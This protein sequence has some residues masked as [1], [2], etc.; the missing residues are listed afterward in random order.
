MTKLKVVS[1]VC[2]IFMAS[3]F[4]GGYFA[5]SLAIMTDAAHLFSDVSGF[6]ISIVSIYLGTIPSSSK[7]NK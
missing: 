3:E 7:V 6:F 5:N 2:I 1:V 4:A